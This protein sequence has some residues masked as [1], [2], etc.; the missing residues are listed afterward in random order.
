MLHGDNPGLDPRWRQSGRQRG[1]AIALGEPGEPR[2]L[3]PR[4]G[5]QAGVHGDDGVGHAVEQRGIEANGGGATVEKILRRHRGHAQHPVDHRTLTAQHRGGAGP[6]GDGD[7][8]AIHPRRMGRV[9][10]QLPPR[11]PFTLGQRCEIEERQEHRLSQFPNRVRADED[12]RGRGLDRRSARQTGEQRSGGSLALGDQGK[13]LPTVQPAPWRVNT[14]RSC[15]RNGMSC[16][17]SI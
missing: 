11:G 1:G 13:I 17:N 8:I 4:E 9:Q 14:V 12:R 5:G 2:R 15:R 10:V 16:Q 3:V 7:D 6:A